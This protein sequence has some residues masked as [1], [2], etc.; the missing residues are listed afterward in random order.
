M[1]SILLTSTALVAFAGAAAADGHATPGIGF[2][3]EAELGYNDDI[4]DGFYWSADVDVTATAALD[5]GVVA[6]ATFGLNIVDEGEEGLGNPVTSSDYVL[7]VEAGS[8]KLSF[9]D[10]DPVAEDRAGL[11]DGMEAETFNDQDTHLITADFEG[12][13]VGETEI[14]GFSAAVS[15]GVDGEGGNDLTGEDLDAMQVYVSG[16]FGSVDVEFAYQEEFGP[17]PEIYAV[18]VSTSVAGADITVAYADNTAVTSTGIQISYPVGPVT[19]G[20]YYTM[21]D[22][23]SDDYGLSAEYADGPIAVEAFYDV[24]DADN[25]DTSDSYGV[26]G[27]YDVGNG[28][29]VLAGYLVND[30]S[31]DSDAYYVAGEYDLGGGA[32]LLVSYAED[33]GNVG[34]DEIGDPEYLHGTTVQVSFT[35]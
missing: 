20:G 14:A 26:E 2:A 33:E 34:N 27:S 1:K 24:A 15:F 17:T 12:I 5:N 10:V 6:T 4:E 9:G 31:A 35:F 3:G 25:A 22:G 28:L 19:V 32:E 23:G 8:S 7:T 21:N 30:E 13:L 18:G 29:T 16:S 11:V